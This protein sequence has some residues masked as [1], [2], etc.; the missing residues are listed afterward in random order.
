MLLLILL[1]PNGIIHA[2]YDNIVATLMYST[3]TL[4][5]CLRFHRVK[6]HFL[7]SVLAFFV[8]FFSWLA[9]FNSLHTDYKLETPLNF[10]AQLRS[11]VVP[12]STISIN[13]S[14]STKSN[15]I[16]AVMRV[17]QQYRPAF[18]QKRLLLHFST[19]ALLQNS[20]LMDQ[21]TYTFI[22]GVGVIKKVRHTNAQ[23]DWRQR[24]LYQTGITAE[25]WLEVIPKTVKV[26]TETSSLKTLYAQLYSTTDLLFSRF[27]SWPFSRSLFL[28]DTSLLSSKDIWQIRFL[29]L[30]HL[31]VVSGL[32]IGFIYLLAQQLANVLWH[33]IPTNTITLISN[34]RLIVFV[35]TT[36]CI[37]FYGSLTNWGEPVQRAVI[38]L[39]IWQVSALF[40]RETSSKVILFT[41]LIFICLL[42]PHAIYSSSLWLSFSLVFLLLCYGQR[43]N[44]RLSAWVKVQLMLSLAGVGLTLGWQDAISSSSFFANLLM[45]P[46]VGFIWFP[47]IFFSCIEVWS[48]HTTWIMS[49]LDYLLGYVLNGLTYLS[50]NS[51]IITLNQ[52]GEISLKIVT[53]LLVLFW[54]IYEKLTKTAYLLL[55]IVICLSNKQT[56]Y[57]GIIGRYPQIAPK[58]WLLK[59]EM[60]NVKLYNQ[61][62]LLQLNT[63]WANSDSE[64]SYFW[65]APML[66]TNKQVPAPKILI[67]PFKNSAINATVIKQ[68]APEWLLLK[69][70]PNSREQV[71]LRGLNVN[72]LELTKKQTIKI[73]L[74]QDYWYIRHSNCLITLK[75][76]VEGQCQR[77]AQLEN[78]LN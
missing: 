54:V 69:Q 47:L 23:G 8:V 28:G 18:F 64:L 6:N 34:K 35:I 74:W 55:L 72:W 19:H 36:P 52:S 20:A 4:L 12:S 9:S 26:K 45:V 48:F 60:N 50:V 76:R 32:H 78:M 53:F 75:L 25:L 24:K 70:M 21:S 49:G 67:W 3:L 51:L 68:L 38:M 37:L 16:S 63:M 33:V 58:V 40:H 2:R 5:C 57:K 62:G 77:V 22:S 31:F 65:L 15:R 66:K 7:L 27:S 44:S 42:Q 29:G 1:I 71:L 46:F 13:S 56:D 17:N 73:E 43:N 59:N 10:T 30:S 61:E 14:I 11:T 39:L 41:S